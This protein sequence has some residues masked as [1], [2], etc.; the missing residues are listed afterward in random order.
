MNRQLARGCLYTCRLH[1]YLMGE[2]TYVCTYSMYVQA[3]SK[4]TARLE[5]AA[6]QKAEQAAAAAAWH[7]V[8]S[9]AAQST[10]ARLY[11]SCVCV[12]LCK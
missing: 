7:P 9:S 2:P 1:A 10:V 8:Q 12:C 3:Q 5:R 6:E 4:K 11:P